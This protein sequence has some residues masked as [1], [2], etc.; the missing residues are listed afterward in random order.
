VLEAS[1]HRQ[2][3]PVTST[4]TQLH[5]S[6]V[7]SCVQL[8]TRAVSAT[9][10]AVYPWQN[11]IMMPHVTA[12]TRALAALEAMWIFSIFFFFF[13]T[14]EMLLEGDEVPRVKGEK[15]DFR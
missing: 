9:R 8:P 3:W 10:V 7:T 5:V 2:P 6:L 1:S 13:V 11:P 12:M 15:A 4:P 14:A